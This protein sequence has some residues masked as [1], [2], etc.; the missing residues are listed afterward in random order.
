MKILS[1]VKSYLNMFGWHGLQIN[2]NINSL[3]HS[4]AIWRWRSWST[5]VQVMACCLTAPSHY[6]NQ[7]WLIISKVQWHSSEVVSP[8]PSVTKVSLKITYLRFQSNLPGANELIHEMKI[9]Y[10][11]QVSVT[12][13]MICDY[14][15]MHMLLVPKFQMIHSIF[16]CELVWFVARTYLWQSGWEPAFI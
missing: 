13:H 8:Q 14:S 3:G 16:T 1:E 15:S 7:C 2:T 9:W 6:L 10:Q 5:L 11:K 4:D 12:P